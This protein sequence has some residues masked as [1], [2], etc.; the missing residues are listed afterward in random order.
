M[1]CSYFYANGGSCNGCCNLVKSTSITLSGTTLTI[2]IPQMQFT[3]NCKLCVVLCQSIPE[4]VSN[5][6]QVVLTSG[7]TTLNLINKCGN[8]IYGDQLRCRR[9]ISMII[10]TDTLNAVVM[11][12]SKLCC[13]TFQFPVLNAPASTAPASAT[14]ETTPVQASATSRAIVI[15]PVDT[16]P[17]E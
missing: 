9:V 3:N 14:T 5:N 11:P 12:W 13:T 17:Y 15:D 8:R 16:L 10:A 4:G 2:T 1:A 6:T 7:T